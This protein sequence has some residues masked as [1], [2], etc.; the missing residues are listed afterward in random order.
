L[1]AKSKAGGVPG[2]LRL[3][4]KGGSIVGW[5]SRN[6]GNN[7]WPFLSE[8]QNRSEAYVAHPS[9][10]TAAAG[11]GGDDCDVQRRFLFSH[12]ANLLCISQKKLPS[13]GVED[14]LHHESHDPV[15]EAASAF[16]PVDRTSQAKS[17]EPKRAAAA[18]QLRAL[19]LVAPPHLHPPRMFPILQHCEV[20]I[21][22]QKMRA[23]DAATK[24]GTR[25]NINDS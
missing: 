23:R 19:S 18:R 7:K 16:V 1:I 5:E 22:L 20:H 9:W 6:S 24:D 25:N 4:T 15:L 2:G 14:A 3:I 8:F 17:Q 21:W 10:T 12:I 11:S 13:E